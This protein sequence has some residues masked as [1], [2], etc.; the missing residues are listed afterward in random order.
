MDATAQ[1]DLLDLVKSE[2]VRL[3]RCLMQGE[4]CELAGSHRA[5]GGASLAD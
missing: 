2:S 3:H 1:R 5:R 4:V